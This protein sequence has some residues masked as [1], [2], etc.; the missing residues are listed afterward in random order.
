[1]VLNPPITTPHVPL[2]LHG[3]TSKLLL[4]TNGLGVTFTSLR[5]NALGSSPHICGRCSGS[6]LDTP[7]HGVDAL[8]ASVTP[9]VQKL[10][11]W[12]SSARGT[13]LHKCS[14]SLTL[15]SSLRVKRLTQRWYAWN[16]KDYKLALTLLNYQGGTK[17]PTTTPHVPLGLHGPISQLL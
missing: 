3:P 12:P 9:R 10:L 7:L 11:I 13:S 8:I 6:T 4:A 14:T 5:D 1:M 2:G 15:L 17:P 16:N